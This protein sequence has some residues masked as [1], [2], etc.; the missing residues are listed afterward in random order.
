MEPVEQLPLSWPIGLRRPS[1][2]RRLGPAYVMG[3]DVQAQL[4]SLGPLTQMVPGPIELK[5]A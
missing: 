3:G 5:S 2:R 4:S 1:W